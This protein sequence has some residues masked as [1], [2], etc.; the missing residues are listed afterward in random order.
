MRKMERGDKVYYGILAM[1]ALAVPV[2]LLIN[3]G[4]ARQ[5]TGR[6]LTEM[7]ASVGDGFAEVGQAVIQRGDVRRLIG[8]AVL[9]IASAIAA[10]LAGLP[11]FLMI[12]TACVHNRAVQRDDRR[13]LVWNPDV[14]VELRRV[15]DVESQ[16]YVPLKK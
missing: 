10:C 6:S 8:P 7:P 2:I 13:E 16:S 4:L 3:A 15:W 14:P 11:F 9:F 5:E 1:F 12:R